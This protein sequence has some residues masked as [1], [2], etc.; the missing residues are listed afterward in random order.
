MTVPIDNTAAVLRQRFGAW[1]KAKREEAGLTQLE[2]CIELDYSQ[3]AM[4]SQVERGS[5]ALPEVDLSLWAD[6][7]RIGREEFAQTYLYYIRPFVWE[8]MHG[9]D[10]FKAEKLPRPA[11]TIKPRP[12][13]GDLKRVK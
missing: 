8:A 11:K 10:P 5:S 1:M 2:L 3:P 13:K 7:L 12:V 9:K 6:L 4:V